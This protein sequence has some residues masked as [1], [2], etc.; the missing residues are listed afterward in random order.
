M[1]RLLMQTLLEVKV[2]KKKMQCLFCLFQ[3]SQKEAPPVHLWRPP[4]Y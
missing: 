3:N 4:G 1:V 2:K